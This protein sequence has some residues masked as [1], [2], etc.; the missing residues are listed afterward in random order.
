MA[1]GSRLALPFGFVE[2][3]NENFG[4]LGRKI[5]DTAEK[6][7]VECRQRARLMLVPGLAFFVVFAFGVGVVLSMLGVE[8]RGWPLALAASAAFLLMGLFGN[9]YQ[10]D[11]D[12]SSLFGGMSNRHT[13]LLVQAWI[14]RGLTTAF[15]VLPYKVLRNLAHLSPRPP[16]IDACVLTTAI[17]VA[18]ALDTSVSVSQLRGIIPREV[19]NE[20]L[21]EAILLL[22][23][24]GLVDSARRGGRNVL[25]PTDRLRNWRLSGVTGSAKV[26][27]LTEL[28][29]G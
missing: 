18:A 22:W 20:A 6:G 1:S 19:S 12:G 13:A 28:M 9:Y 25:L 24:G 29:T 5:I 4:D 23:W 11:F 27:R 26:V 21:N 2:P 8:L 16:A 10:S 7:I 14:V 3:S 17:Q 15:F